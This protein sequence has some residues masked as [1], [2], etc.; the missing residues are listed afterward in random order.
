[1]STSIRMPRLRLYLS[2]LV[3]LTCPL[4]ALY[5][6]TA[7]G[8]ATYLGPFLFVIV[9]PLLDLVVGERQSGRRDAVEQH[10]SSVAVFLIAFLPVQFAAVALALWRCRMAV[11]W[12]SFAGMSLACGLGASV[13]IVAAH[14]LI[15][16]ASKPKRMVGDAIMTLVAYTHFGLG[17]RTGH[18]KKAATNEDPSTARLGES[19]YAYLARALVGGWRASWSHEVKRLST[20]GLSCWHPSNEVFRFAVAPLVVGASAYCIA[21][22]AGLTFFALQSFVAVFL[23]ESVSY[24]QHYGLTRK[25]LPTRRYE[26]LAGRHCWDCSLLVSNMFLLNIPLHADH[27]LHPQMSFARLEER[28]DSQKLPAGYGAMITLA[29]VPPLW[30][31]VMDLR[32]ETALAAKGARDAYPRPGSSTTRRTPSRELQAAHS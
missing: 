24:I 11:D 16:A 6:T 13:A 23:L 17:H 19:L 20:R 21:G 4:A 1:M 27:H 15:H 12:V 3:G 14:D 26:P 7:S 32:A 18:H 30:R 10:K 29:M 2:L 5:A 9:V 28:D 31:R 8:L 25:L 22:T